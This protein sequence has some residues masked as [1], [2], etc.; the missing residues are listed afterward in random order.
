MV[1]NSTFCRIDFQF[2]TW[3]LINIEV[4]R[5][6][7]SDCTHF[8]DHVSNL[9]NEYTGVLKKIFA[10]RQQHCTFFSYVLKAKYRRNS[11]LYRMSSMKCK[12][13]T[14]SDAHEWHDFVAHCTVCHAT[15]TFR[16]CNRGVCI[17]EGYKHINMLEMTHGTPVTV[18]L[19]HLLV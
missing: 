13:L 4:K 5:R 12:P 15:K 1:F 10:L 6:I 18:R 8:H 3:Q 14:Q 11:L 19:G 9:F 16:Y 2:N 7:S 17:L